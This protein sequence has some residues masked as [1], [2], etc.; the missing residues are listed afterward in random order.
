VVWLGWAY[1][2]VTMLGI[3]SNSLAAA[4]TDFWAD[5]LALF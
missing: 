5:L 2:I 3:E 4:S 1:D